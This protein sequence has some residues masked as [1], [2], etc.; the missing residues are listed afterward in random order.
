LVQ[1]GLPPFSAIQPGPLSHLM[2]GW[3]FAFRSV[4]GLILAALVIP[5]LL[6]RIRSEEALLHTQFGDQYEAYC[7]RTSR[8]IPGIY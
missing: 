3:A 2:L 1:A 6:A 4:P 8:L 7:R 5:P